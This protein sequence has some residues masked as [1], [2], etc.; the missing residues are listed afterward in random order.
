MRTAV[1]SSQM[2]DALQ[3][4]VMEALGITRISSFHN[5]PH[6]CQCLI[7]A[8]SDFVRRGEE[9]LTPLGDDPHLPTQTYLAVWQGLH[10]AP[11]ESHDTD[12]DTTEELPPGAMIAAAG[13]PGLLSDV[14]RKRRSGAPGANVR[15]CLVSQPEYTRARSC[16]CTTVHSPRCHCTRQKYVSSTAV[17]GASIALTAAITTQALL[18]NVHRHAGRAQ[19]DA[20]GAP[21]AARLHARARR[22]HACHAS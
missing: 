6:L 22:R 5:V 8:F 17:R 2:S 13:H 9:A 19:L 3:A 21:L 16:T 7:V 14:P 10:D 18:Q 1:E 15:C 20:Q 11:P 4:A 12:E